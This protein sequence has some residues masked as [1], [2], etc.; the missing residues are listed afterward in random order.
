ME[1][2]KQ[3]Q[4]EKISELKDK[5]MHIRAMILSLLKSL[6]TKYALRYSET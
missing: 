4:V 3:E 5:L 1:L 2:Q 6:E